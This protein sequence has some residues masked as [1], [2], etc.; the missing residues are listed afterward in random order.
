MLSYCATL[1]V[2]IATVLTVSG[3]LTA[4]AAPTNACPHQRSAT[5]WVQA[6]L[7]LRWLE[8][9]TD[10][11]DLAGDSGGSQAT[12]YWHRKPSRS[13]PSGLPTTSLT[14]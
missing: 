13:S 8:D 14:S 5:S 9:G 7:L 3:W 10:V 1:D 6:V 12:A 11:R 2:S 4:P